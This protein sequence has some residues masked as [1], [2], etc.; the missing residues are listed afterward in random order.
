VRQDIRCSF[1]AEKLAPVLP[2]PR[3]R[4]PRVGK[5]LFETIVFIEESTIID[6]DNQRSRNRK[7]SGLVGSSFFGCVVWDF[8]SCIV[9]YFV[10]GNCE[11]LCSRVYM[12]V[13]DQ[14]PL[15]SCQRVI[16]LVYSPLN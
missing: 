15:V 3:K 12:L 11:P 4:V 7:V 14:C 16:Y 1:D 5:G 10:V 6:C 8:L 2:E 9:Q 13:G